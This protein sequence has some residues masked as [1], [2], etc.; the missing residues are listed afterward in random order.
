[1]FQTL[2]SGNFNKKVEK[3]MMKKF[4][5]SQRKMD[6]LKSWS[7]A[8]QGNSENN[9]DIINEIERIKDVKLSIHDWLSPRIINDSFD[10]HEHHITDYLLKFN[11]RVH[12]NEETRKKKSTC[13]IVVAV[14]AQLLYEKQL[15]KPKELV[16][17]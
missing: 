13:A 14:T 11:K 8:I 15:K 12:D 10:S 4:N 7:S 16:T 17:V 9:C 2:A 5:L 6:T 3:T 1:M